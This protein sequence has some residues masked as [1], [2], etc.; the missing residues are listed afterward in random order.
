M[1]KVTLSIGVCACIPDLQGK[2]EGREIRAN[3]TTFVLSEQKV[4]DHR[5]HRCHVFV[6]RH[7]WKK[8]WLNDEKFYECVVD[9]RT[10]SKYQP[11]PR[12][13]PE[14]VFALYKAIGTS[15][16]R[17]VQ[18]PG[19]EIFLEK[20]KELLEDFL[21]SRNLKEWFNAFEKVKDLPLLG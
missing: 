18:R 9:L 1:K 4:P 17:Q 5:A 14:A 19:C 10:G 11:D 3:K 15:E 6:D 8:S 20:L 12:F 2:F 16:W 7:F 13:D 21:K